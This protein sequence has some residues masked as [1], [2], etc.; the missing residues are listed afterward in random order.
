M[1]C[2]LVELGIGVGR[3]FGYVGEESDQQVNI[4]SFVVRYDRRWLALNN[5][6]FILVQATYPTSSLSRSLL[7]S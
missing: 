5:I 6:G 4:Y 3:V 7:Y 1:L 2:S